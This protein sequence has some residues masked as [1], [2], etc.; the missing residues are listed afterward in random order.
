[1]RTKQPG[2]LLVRVPPWA[3]R[4]TLT[5]DGVAGQSVG[6][7]GYL[8]IDEPKALAGVTIAMPPPDEEIALVHRTRTIRARLRGDAVV[9]VD[10]F[11][12]DLTFFDPLQG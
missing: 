11:G 7:D 4:A 2:H 5:V 1:M 10:N 3:D 12:A 9:A 8:A 6:A